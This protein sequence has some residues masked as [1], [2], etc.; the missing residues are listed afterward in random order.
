LNLAHNGG[1]TYWEAKALL[2]LGRLEK[3]RGNHEHSQALFKHALELSSKLGAQ[4][5]SG[6]I[7]SELK[8]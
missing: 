7:S 3:A 5:L 6:Q 1:S 4:A 2:Y 8:Q